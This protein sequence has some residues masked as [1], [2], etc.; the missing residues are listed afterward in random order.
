MAVPQ[1]QLANLGEIYA[2]NQAKQ[3]AMDTMQLEQAAAVEKMRQDQLARQKQAQL[4]EMAKTVDISTPEGA[5]QAF[6]SGLLDLKAYQDVQKA[7]SD[8]ALAKQRTE[9]ARIQGETS[10]RT[11]SAT[12]RKTDAQIAKWGRDSNLDA[13]RTA[14]AWQQMRSTLSQQQIEIGANVSRALAGI[15]D[16]KQRQSAYTQSL[17]ILRQAFPDFEFSENVDDPDLTAAMAVMGGMG[18]PQKGTTGKP[19]AVIDPNTGQAIYVAPDQAIGQQVAST[20]TQGQT[21]EQ[22][23][24]DKAI[25]K[26]ETARAEVAA[27]ASGV[28]D[29]L[30]RAEQLVS[31]GAATTGPYISK[32]PT[33]SAGTAEFEAISN[34]LGLQG[35]AL[36]KGSITEAENR[37][38]QSTQPGGDRTPESNLAII[39]FNRS[40]MQRAVERGKFDATWRQTKGTIGGADA[41]WQRFIQENPI[42][43]NKPD[44]LS[45]NEANIG[46]WQ[47][48][49]TG[50]GRKTQPAPAGGGQGGVPTLSPAE[51]S[52]LP[53]GSKFY[54]SD[55]VLRIKQ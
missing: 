15:S 43:S 2:Q 18:K 42:T 40:I 1:L 4:L 22:Q 21:K 46:N 10:L 33:L 49:I 35:T 44:D 34:Q 48:Y 32:L 45:I 7:A 12:E 11:A 54:G 30:N 14:I 36:L 8:M 25:V 51:A 50:E 13:Q 53:S 19:V 27:N 3:A 17:P 5:K 9:T 24:R 37:K 39:K 41:A 20:R 29:S 28:I 52:Q 38:V 47:G 23:E 55:G 6:Q 16:P 26:A 31:S